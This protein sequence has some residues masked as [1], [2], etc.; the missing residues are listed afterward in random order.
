MDRTAI[1]FHTKGAT[2][3]CLMSVGRNDFQTVSPDEIIDPNL[4]KSSSSA[5]R[6][7]MD[8]IMSFRQQDK[9]NGYDGVIIVSFEQLYTN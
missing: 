2:D 9:K 8:C 6:D 7:M 1:Q 5:Q 3:G 4:P